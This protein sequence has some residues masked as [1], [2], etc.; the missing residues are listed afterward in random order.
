MRETKGKRKSVRWNNYMM[1]YQSYFQGFIMKIHVYKYTTMYVQIFFETL[2]IKTKYW[3][4]PKCPFIE[5][6][7]DKK[8]NEKTEYNKSKEN[9]KL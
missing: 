3:K 2:F 9:I 5:D 6:F 7:N 4:Q 1:I 8:T